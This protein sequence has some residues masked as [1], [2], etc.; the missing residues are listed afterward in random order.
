MLPEILALSQGDGNL[1]T[2]LGTQLDPISKPNE[3]VRNDPSFLPPKKEIYLSVLFGQ[4]ELF[5][6]SLDH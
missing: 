5:F 6:P 1:E 4:R 3:K 2:S